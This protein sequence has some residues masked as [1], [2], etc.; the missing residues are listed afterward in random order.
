MRHVV[1]WAARAGAFRHRGRCPGSR[2]RGAAGPSGRTNRGSRRR[3][4]MIRA[5]FLSL[6]PRSEPVSSREIVDCDRPTRHASWRCERPMPRRLSRIDSPMAARPAWIASSRVARMPWSNGRQ[7]SMTTR[8]GVPPNPAIT[9]RSTTS[10]LACS[11]RE[12]RVGAAAVSA[13]GPTLAR[14]YG[15]QGECMTTMGITC[16]DACPGL[17]ARPDAQTAGRSGRDGRAGYRQSQVEGASSGSCTV[18]GRSSSS[19]GVHAQ[20]AP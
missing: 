12:R 13:P 20:A 3:A 4:P 5:R 16:G 6:S 7:V 18:V 11:G 9:R 17:P 8:L 15:H 19:A 1:R 2:R 14:I 10:Y